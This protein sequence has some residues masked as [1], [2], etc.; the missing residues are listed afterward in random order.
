MAEVSASGPALLMAAWNFNVDVAFLTGFL[1]VLV[2]FEGVGLT[3]LTTFL[4]SFS[5]SVVT[6]SL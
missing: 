2:V 1:R 4:F 6:E 5:S 3:L